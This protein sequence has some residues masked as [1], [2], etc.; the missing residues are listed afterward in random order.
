MITLAAMMGHS[1]IQM[2]MRYAHPTQQHQTEA[3]ARLERYNIEQQIER[4]PTVSEA[5]Q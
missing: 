2:V 5:I 3:I 1:K 4:T